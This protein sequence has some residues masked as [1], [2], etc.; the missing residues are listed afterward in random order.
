MA[1]SGLSPELEARA[2]A[3]LERV[4]N[5]FE[6]FREQLDEAGVLL[7]EPAQHFVAGVAERLVPMLEQMGDVLEAATVTDGIDALV[8]VSNLATLVERIVVYLQGAARTH[9]FSRTAMAQ[10]LARGHVDA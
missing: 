10:V 7:D 1:I 5:A 4:D 8:H 3:A 6:Q 2:L 9:T